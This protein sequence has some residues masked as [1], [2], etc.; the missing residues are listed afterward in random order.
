[1][2]CLGMAVSLPVALLFVAACGAME[3]LVPMMLTSMVSG[4]VVGMLCAMV[5]LTL[6]EALLMG[7]ATGVIGIAV[8]WILNNRL[9]GVQPLVGESEHG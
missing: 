2:M 5:D 9:R 7:V 8:I 1:M 3:V 6:L 4:M